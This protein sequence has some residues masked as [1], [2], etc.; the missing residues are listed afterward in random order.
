MATLTITEAPQAIY[1]DGLQDSFIIK[2]DGPFTVYVDSDSSIDAKSHPIPP[3]GSM[4]WDANRPLW[5]RCGA[6]NASDTGFIPATDAS[7]STVIITRNSTPAQFTNET[8]AVLLVKDISIINLGDNHVTYPIM[9]CTAFNSLIFTFT[10]NTYRY[11]SR[12]GGITAQKMYVGTVVWYDHTGAIIGQDIFNCP[13]Q[14]TFSDYSINGSFIPEYGAR[15]TM[16]VRG[17]FFRVYLEIGWD[18]VASQQIHSTVIGTT[19]TLPKRMTWTPYETDP[20]VLNGQIATSL[21]FVTADGFAS[22]L[23]S[24]VGFPWRSFILP[25]ISETVRIR[26]ITR[27]AGSTAGLVYFNDA[28]AQGIQLYPSTTFP[29][30]IFSY[31]DLTVNLPIFRPNM[32]T[33]N[34]QVLNAGNPVAMSLHV[35]YL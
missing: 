7:T 23:W 30:A 35:T 15:I 11:T 25:G 22:A 33:V 10:S 1:P 8:D 29:A 12:V 27:S 32:F 5:M 34:A 18:A 3:T 4:A 24:D 16:P 9:E 14:T 20:H 28:I 2:N 26:M 21:D 19:R 6:I 31:V 13:A 17:N